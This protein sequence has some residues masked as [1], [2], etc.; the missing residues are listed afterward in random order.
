VGETRALSGLDGLGALRAP[1]EAALDRMNAQR[2]ADRFNQKDGTVWSPDAARA[3]EIAGWMGWLDVVELL[4]GRLQ[5]FEIARDQVDGRKRFDHIVLAGMGGSSLC[6]DVLRN[7]FGVI[8]GW[9]ELLVLDSTDP[10][11]IAA[12]ESRIDPARTLFFISSK[13]GGTL[14]TL[15]HYRYFHDLLRRSG[16]PNHGRHFIAITD[17]GSSLEK[18][19]RENDF[20]HVYLNPPDIGG[21]YSALSYF[22]MAPAAVMGLDVAKLLGIA[23][24]MRESCRESDAHANPGL[25]LGAVLGAA[26]TS[27]RDKCTIICSPQVATLGM[28]LE[29]LLAESTGKEGKGIIPVE[30]EPVGMPDGYGDD[31]LFAYVR[32]PQGCERLDPQVEALRAAGHPVYTIDVQGPDE[33]GAEFMRWEV[34]TAIAGAVIGINP[35]DQPNVQES[36]DNTKAV[37]DRCAESGDFGVEVQA[38]P[39]GEVEKLLGELGPGD[40]FALLAY[41]QPGDDVDEHLHAIRVTVRDGRHVATTSS[42]GPRYLHST[43]QLHKG[44]PNSGVFLI[45]SDDRG[46]ELPIPETPFGF[47]TLIH[48]QWAGDLKSLR[49]HGRRA[50]ML[51]MGEDPA[52][53]LARLQEVVALASTR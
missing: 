21:R 19:A 7:T 28:W 42:Y 27:G 18:I 11:T 20:G 43:G 24:Q 3:E 48:A 39:M 8:D 16:V 38:D 13:S 23:Q 4:L 45:L 15:S 31:R 2:W 41:T 17:A 6:P 49:D 36:K 33:L 9:P 34:A 25:E 46:Q 10:S 51:P 5:E 35:F 50:A 26:A 53:T 30:G 37:L 47:K 1:V 44:G 12:V 40:Y 14:E 22:G 32:T 29:Q 52:G